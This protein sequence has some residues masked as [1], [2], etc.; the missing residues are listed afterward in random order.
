MNIETFFNTDDV[1]RFFFPSKI[2]IGNK[3]SEKA[4]DLLAHYK[5]I[6]IVVDQVFA[7]SSIYQCLVDTNKSATVSTWVVR[8]PPFAQDIIEFVRRLDYTPPD[9]VVSVGGG[10]A[11]DFAK[12]IILNELFGTID[13]VGVGEK[14]GMPQRDGARRPLYIAIPTT[15]GSGAEASRYFVTYDKNTHGKV[16]GKTWQ[17]IADWIFLDPQHL[18]SMPDSAL[19][20]CAFDAFVH[21]FETLVVKHERSS[22]GDMLSLDGIPR[23]MAALERSFGYGRRDV[24]VH[25][26]LLYASTLAGVAISNVRTGN[27]HEA[28][29]A[30]LELTDLSHPETLF[31]FFRDAIEQYLSQITDREQALLARLR[32]IPAFAQFAC[33]DDVIRWWEALFARVGI[34]ERIQ[35]SLGRLAPSQE[36]VKAHIFQRVFTDKVWITKESPLLLDEAGISR[37]IDRAL[38]RFS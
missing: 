2:F 10:S 19:V 7:G 17:V 31:V 4:A 20:S 34:V 28:A 12:S 26:D 15:A 5:S 8:G 9:V 6:V 38:G 18:A 21:L 23:I 29:G 36:A 14:R 25:E 33:M 22:F 24:Q 16:H 35:V 1:K 32:L 27:I 13:G 3:I 11:A 37:F 30:L